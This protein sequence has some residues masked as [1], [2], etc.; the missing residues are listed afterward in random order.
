M[1]K[2]RKVV[3]D[4]ADSLFADQDRAERDLFSGIQAYSG[5]CVCECVRESFHACLPVRLFMLLV[6]F[7]HIVCVCEGRHGARFVIASNVS[8]Q[9]F[10]VS[11]FNFI[12]QSSSPECIL[13]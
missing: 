4:D 11:A 9:V 6:R 3:G 2:A 10:F 5:M 7:G 8:L 1:L 13:V 12:Q